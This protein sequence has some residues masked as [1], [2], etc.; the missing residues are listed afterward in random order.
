[1][2]QTVALKDKKKTLITQIHEK[3]NDITNADNNKLKKS[4]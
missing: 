1:V 2:K 3:F 4:L